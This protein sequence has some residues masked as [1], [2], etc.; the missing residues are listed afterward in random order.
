MTPGR[1]YVTDSVCYLVTG[2]EYIYEQPLSMGNQTRYPDFTIED[3]E[4]GRKIYWE[5]CG[6]LL[7]PEYK[8][9]WERKLEWYRSSKIS[10]YEEG[11]GENGILIVTQDN[12]LGGISSK[13][14][15]QIIKLVMLKG[16]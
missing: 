10:P 6:L 7:D 8:K 13:D 3:E 2:I 14:I 16:N 4:S 12:E 1:V 11:E 9:G 5:H 15:D